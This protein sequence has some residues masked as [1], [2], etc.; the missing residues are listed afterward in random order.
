MINLVLIIQIL[1]NALPSTTIKPDEVTGHPFYVSITEAQIVNDTLQISVRVFTD[2]LESALS[3]L[4]SSKVFLNDP[5]QREK[6]FVMIRDYIFN[7]LQVGNSAKTTRI[8]WI[9]HE[10]EDD[11]CWIY[12]Y[13]P[14]AQDQRMLFI[15]H[16]LLYEVYEDQQNIVHFKRNGAY[17]TELATKQKPEVRFVIE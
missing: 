15:K 10:F 16:L 12:G 8:E 13:M 17:S 2:D 9:G 7:R 1:L 4:N 6:E 5:S 11:V 14:M 3:K